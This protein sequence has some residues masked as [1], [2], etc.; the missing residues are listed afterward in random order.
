MVSEQY[1]MFGV[2]DWRRRRC[3]GNNELNLNRGECKF[4]CS[5]WSWMKGRGF[6]EFGEERADAL[7]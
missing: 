4:E 3:R 5:G 7:R 1:Q 2:C 6:K